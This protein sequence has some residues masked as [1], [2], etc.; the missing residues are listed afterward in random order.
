[1]TMTKKSSG[2][3]AWLVTWDWATAVAAVPERD[4]VAAV[5]KPQ[6]G[7][8]TVMGYVEALYA[9]REYAAVDKLD[10]L[11][12]N[13]YPAQSVNHGREVVCGHN[14]MLRACLVENLREKDPG[15]P[16]AGLIWDE[17]PRPELKMPS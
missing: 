12:H 1:M 3:K 5:L 6:L 2:H 16:E 15:N 17:L 4:V 10:A 14:P 13:S 9:Q 8:K 7:I 11:A